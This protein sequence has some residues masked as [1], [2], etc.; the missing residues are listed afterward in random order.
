MV[1]RAALYGE[2]DNIIQ[3]ITA[4]WAR[5]AGFLNPDED[6][7]AL[8][9]LS[10][11]KK[12]LNECD[13]LNLKGVCGVFLLRAEKTVIK[14]ALEKTNWNRKKAAGLLEISYKSLLNKIKEYE[15]A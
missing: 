10:N 2:N 5:Q 14:K 4:Q 1:N 15:L 3:N 6:I 8:A 11:L 9:G 13:N 12:Y 7:Y